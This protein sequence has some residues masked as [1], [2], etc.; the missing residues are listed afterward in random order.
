V[1]NAALDAVM[2]A[3]VGGVEAAKFAVLAVL[4]AF[5]AFAA[6]YFGMRKVAVLLGAKLP[7]L[8]AADEDVPGSNSDSVRDDEYS[9]HVSDVKRD[10]RVDS[11]SNASGSRP[12]DFDRWVN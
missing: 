11:W 6:A 3:G 4:G 2:S 8:W 5:V 12:A 1:A 7:P 9:L 10:S